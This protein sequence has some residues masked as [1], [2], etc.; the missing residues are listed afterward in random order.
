MSNSD[1]GLVQL[2]RLLFG[3]EIRPTAICPGRQKPGQMAL[4]FSAKIYLQIEIRFKHG[5]LVHAGQRPFAQAARS[6]GKRP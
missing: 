4:K 1:F 5:K 3:K 6:Q 2:P